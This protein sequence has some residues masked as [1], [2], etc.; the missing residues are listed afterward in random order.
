MIVRIQ[1]H[2]GKEESVGRALVR[3][4][5]LWMASALLPMTVMAAVL[6]LWRLAADLRLAS[7]FAISDGP[8]S[9]WQAWAATATC[10]ALIANL[11]NRFGRSGRVVRG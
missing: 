10:T 4:L 8:F 11:L 3:P 2:H 9:H 5:A 1:V 7:E 6:C